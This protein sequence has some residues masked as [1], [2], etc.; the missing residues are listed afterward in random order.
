MNNGCLDMQK[1]LVVALGCLVVVCR[2][3]RFEKTRWGSLCVLQVMIQSLW[4]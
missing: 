2:V 1:A 4:P 3:W